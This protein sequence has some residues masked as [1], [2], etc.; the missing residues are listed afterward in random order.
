MPLCSWCV[1]E[2]I[3]KDGIEIS[4]KME[5]NE[6]FFKACGDFDIDGNYLYMYEWTMGYLFKIDMETGK[7]VKTIASR[8]QGPGELDFAVKLDVKNG[9]IFV[10]DQNYRGI[11]VFTTDGA[12]VKEFKIKGYM[13]D[14]GITVDDKEHIYLGKFDF[15][16]KTMVS[17]YD[18]TGKKLRS[19]I[20]HNI[21]VYDRSKVQ[22]HE[23]K[24]E[25]DKSGNI[26]LLFPVM[27]I[28]KKYD[29]SGKLIWERE[30]D[31]KLIVKNPKP[32]KYYYNGKEQ[33][34]LSRSIGDFT[35]MDNYEI[36]ISHSKGGCILDKEG[37]LKKII[38]LQN[39]DLIYSLRLIKVVGDR[40]INVCNYKRNVCSFKIK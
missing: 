27:R 29:N 39:N 16:N 36:L 18:N 35:I 10:A 38:K 12:L 25:M 6:V 37:K 11:K 31:N 28:I 3:L 15:E 13:W 1:E 30:I 5:E 21:N 33:I 40:V 14:I 20:K 32:G 26:Y 23:Y 19:F 4:K 17:V 2:F 22:Q 8:G 24:M 34:Y 9:K 7:L